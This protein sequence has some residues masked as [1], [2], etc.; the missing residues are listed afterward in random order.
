[1]PLAQLLLQ[2]HEYVYFSIELERGCTRETQS[3]TSHEIMSWLDR[4]L[5]GLMNDY[6]QMEAEA[7]WWWMEEPKRHRTAD[8]AANPYTQGMVA[9]F[10]FHPSHHHQTLFPLPLPAAITAA[11]TRMLNVAEK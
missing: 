5:N 10:L 2:K 9:R 8:D 1:M 4:L 6:G 7:G 3:S 11:D